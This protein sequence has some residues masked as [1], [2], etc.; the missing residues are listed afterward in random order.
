VLVQAPS[1]ATAL[2][3][4]PSD[5]PS[6]PLSQAVEVSVQAVYTAEDLVTFVG[7]TGTGYVIDLTTGFIFTEGGSAFDPVDL[8]LLSREEA[9]RLIASRKEFKK[10]LFADAI[11]KLEEDPSIA[12]VPPCE[13][14][15]AADTGLCQITDVQ[16][17]QIV[18]A[19]P[20]QIPD[21]QPQQIPD[22]QPQ[23]IADAQR[24]PATAKVAPAAARPFGYRVRVARLPQIERKIAVLFGVNDYQDTRIPALDNSVSDASAVG[25]LLRDKL[26]YEV[27]VIRNARKADI[28]RALNRLAVETEADDSVIVYYAGHGDVLEKTGIGYWMPSDAAAD[29]PKQWISNTDISRMLSRIGARQ[30][31]MISDSCY[32]GAFTK[33]QKVALDG[34]K[35]RPETVLTR[36]SVVVMSSGGDEPVADSGRGGHSIF[37]WH[38]MQDLAKIDN[39]EPGAVLFR[40]VQHQVS[41]AFPQ[42]PQYGGSTSAGHQAGGD[43]LFEFRQLETAR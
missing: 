36:R 40:D 38:L 21:A 26:G 5:D 37:A 41:R 8:S 1:N 3:L 16:R 2:R 31:A 23:Q 12:R 42:T 4:F 29:D 30:V 28:V 19:R 9:E 43:Y 10:K 27:R 14:I 34:D 20:Q 17:Q 24:Q 11:W 33:E 13:S 35:I 7:D 6:S 32:S 39:W 22:A 15:A 18:D 25:G